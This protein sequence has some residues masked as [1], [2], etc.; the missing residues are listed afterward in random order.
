MA[1]YGDRMRNYLLA[2]LYARAHLNLMEVELSLSIKGFISRDKLKTRACY[3][4]EES[5]SPALILSR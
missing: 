1:L 2:L 3:N 5:A 4:G